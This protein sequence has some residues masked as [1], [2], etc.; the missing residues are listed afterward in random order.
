[1]FSSS[2][3]VNEPLGTFGHVMPEIPVMWPFVE[4]ALL[5]HFY[6]PVSESMF[7]EN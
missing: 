5:L 6:F 2:G 1:M 7:I 4:T 3:D